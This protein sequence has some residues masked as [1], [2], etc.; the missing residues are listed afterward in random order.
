MDLESYPTK[1][2]RDLRV[3]SPQPLFR[4]L[5]DLLEESGFRLHS[6][7]V[8][9]LKV[10]ALPG[11]ATFN[12]RLLGVRDSTERSGKGG[13]GIPLIAFGGIIIAVMVV[14][15]AAV[16][17]LDA[18]FPVLGMVAWRD[19]AGQRSGTFARAP[20][21]D[22]PAGPHPDGGRELSGGSDPGQLRRS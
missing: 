14:L 13:A 21:P 11:T 22:P 10:G 9:E 8:P 18:I 5:A 6:S 1:L 12:G 17:S 2:K 3:S 4:A 16:D 20:A 19:L 15:L 7:E